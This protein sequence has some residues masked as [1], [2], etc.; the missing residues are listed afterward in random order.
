M[1]RHAEKTEKEL[2]VNAEFATA[3]LAPEIDT[4]FI[5]EAIVNETG[6][7]IGHVPFAHWLMPAVRPRVLVELGTHRG[8]SLDAFNRSIVG[9]TT[10]TSVFAVDTWQGDHQADYSQGTPIYE[11]VSAHNDR[12]YGGFSKLMRM[13]FDEALPKFQDASVDV[14][15]IDG[16]HTYDAVRHDFESWLPKMSDRG[17][18]LFHDTNVKR[19]DFG[20]WKLWDELRQKHWGFQFLHSNGLGVLVVGANAP[21]VFDQLKKLPTDELDARFLRRFEVLGRRWMAEQ[22]LF[23]ARQSMKAKDET[24]LDFHRRDSSLGKRLAYLFTG[25]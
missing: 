10:A 14:L 1:S 12:Y 11:A 18:V 20:V 7:W 5:D 19:D 4:L 9:Q 6:A 15:H 13:T 17:I 24:I 23:M 22:Q 25:R 21:T 2:D 3:L 8:V 16:L